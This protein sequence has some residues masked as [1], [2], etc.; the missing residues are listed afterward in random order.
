MFSYVFQ[1]PNVILTALDSFASTSFY[2][3][4]YKDMPSKNRA[5]LV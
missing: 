4:V 1:E 5:L 3:V 2:A